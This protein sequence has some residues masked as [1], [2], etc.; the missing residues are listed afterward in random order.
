MSLHRFPVCF[1]DKLKEVM[2]QQVLF[3]FSKRVAVGFVHQREG[4]IRKESANRSRDVFQNARQARV[5]IL[6]VVL[7]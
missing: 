1:R 5:E 4:S 3:C 2:A 7:D 6:R